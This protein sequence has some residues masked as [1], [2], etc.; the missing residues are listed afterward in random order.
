MKLF[1]LCSNK[2]QCDSKYSKYG[3]GIR[4]GLFTA[5]PKDW[6]IIKE[7]LK[8]HFKIGDGKK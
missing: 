8:N 6:K 3:S 1:P 2:H 4:V 7:H 5:K